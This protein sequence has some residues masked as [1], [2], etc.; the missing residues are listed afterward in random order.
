[1]G[2]RDELRAHQSAL[3]AEDMSVELLELAAADVVVGI[4]RRGVEMGI[5]HL[6][7]THGIEYLQGV[8][9]SDFIDM[10]EKR[11]GLGKDLFLEVKDLLGK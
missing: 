5:G 11:L 10:G 3:G 2:A 8:G 4:A 6:A 7:F 9:L 1:M